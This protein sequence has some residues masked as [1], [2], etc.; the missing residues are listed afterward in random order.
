MFK[1]RR[2]PGNG[3]LEGELKIHRVEPTTKFKVTEMFSIYF[4]TSNSPGGHWIKELFLYALLGIKKK[5]ENVLS[6]KIR[7]YV[8]R[9]IN[10]LSW[11][12]FGV[13]GSQFGS[14]ADLWVWIKPEGEARVRV[15]M[16]RFPGPNGM[17]T[18]ILLRKTLPRRQS[19][20]L[21]GDENRKMEIQLRALSSTIKSFQ[22]L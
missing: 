19:L 9:A 4:H 12:C 21:L 7:I 22:V 8:K 14:T 20:R 2:K 15:L 11:R 3:E 6:N 18:M 13:D 1:S 10:K 16:S 17:D 5:E